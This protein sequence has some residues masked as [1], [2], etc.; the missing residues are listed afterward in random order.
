MLDAS[1]DA[2]GKEVQE[3]FRIPTALQIVA[4]DN[5]VLG[6][7]FG[8]PSSWRDFHNT[9]SPRRSIVALSVLERLL[10]PNVGGEDAENEKQS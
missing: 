5:H 6:N 3:L 10:V 9:P 2:P 8:D 4:D 1:G 7:V